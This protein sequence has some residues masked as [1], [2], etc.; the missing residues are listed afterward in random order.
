MSA[1]SAP[2]L[3]GLAAGGTS[4]NDVEMLTSSLGMGGLA[5][6]EEGVGPETEDSE[7]LAE[8]VGTLCDEI[9]GSATLSGLSSFAGFRAARF[10]RSSDMLCFFRACSETLIGVKRNSISALERS[11]TVLQATDLSQIWAVCKPGLVGWAR[12]FRN[13]SLALEPSQ[14][15][16]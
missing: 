12:A 1:C 9:S 7:V 5:D 16:R 15:H 6:E 13:K 8:A 11:C 2:D 3:A 10:G 4:D 14:A